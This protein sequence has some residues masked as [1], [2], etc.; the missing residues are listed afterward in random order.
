MGRPTSDL[1]KECNIIQTKQSSS[2]LG[3]K[4][5][6]TATMIIVGVIVSLDGLISKRYCKAECNF[7][8]F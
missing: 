7:L 3:G 2:A 5:V 8:F 4:T 6:L 1:S